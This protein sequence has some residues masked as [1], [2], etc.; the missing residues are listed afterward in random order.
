MEIPTLQWSGAQV[1]DGKLVV[2]LAGDRPKGWKSSFDRTVKLLNNSRWGSVTLK[3]GK[4]RVEGVDEGTEESLHHFLE[5]VM[6]EVNA[7]LVDDDQGA[8]AEE[9]GAPDD[10]GADSADDRMTERFRGLHAS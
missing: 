10:D 6:Q 4:V 5:S 1:K 8:D 3:A 7:A 9:P 2:E